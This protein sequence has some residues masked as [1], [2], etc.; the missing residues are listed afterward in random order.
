MNRKTVW[1]LAAVGLVLLAVTGTRWAGAR[2]ATTAAAAAASAPVQAVE[3]APDDVARV[4][5]V[6]LAAQLN[7]S[8]GLKA[9]DSAVVKARVAADVRQLLVREGDRVVAGQL[10]GKLDDTEARLRLK[11][12]DDNASAARAQLD[13]AQRT[14]E[15]NRALVGQGFISKTALDTAQNGVNGAQATLQAAQAAADLLRKA[16]KDTELRAPLAGWVSQR[17]VQPGERVSL[18]ARLLEVV[19]LNKLELEAAVAPEEVLALRVGQTAQVQV[20]GLAAPLP[21][22]VV[23]IS[24]SA[25]AGSRVVLAYLRL[26]ASAQAS[27]LRQGLFARARV[28]LARSPALVVPASALRFDQA[29]PYVLVFSQGQALARPVDIGRRGLA[30]LKHGRAE[31]AVEVTN[32]LDEGDTV[33]RGSVGALRAGTP[34]KLAASAA[35]TPAVAAASR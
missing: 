25:Q 23:R 11:Q 24:P 31:E 30:P 1:A 22:T 15:N 9:L 26:P 3:L 20:D 21:A 16:V 4:L 32:G 34:L 8:G 18:D 17:L 27:G 29:K 19:D 12:A 7:V 5:R 35:A 28:E 10:L 33:L 6:E 13:T 14:L 2:K